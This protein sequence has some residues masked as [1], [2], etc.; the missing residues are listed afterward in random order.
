MC[1]VKFKPAFLGVDVARLTLSGWLIGVEAWVNF[2]AI[3][4]LFT[5][6]TLDCVVTMSDS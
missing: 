2:N 4:I 6:H 1:P 3:L 5:P